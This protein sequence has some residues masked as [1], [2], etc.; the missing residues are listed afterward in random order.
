M[1]DAR[2]LCCTIS[3]SVLEARAYQQRIHNRN[4]RLMRQKPAMI[5]ADAC[6]HDCVNEDQHSKMHGCTDV[7]SNAHQCE[8][9]I[10]EQLKREIH[11]H[12][13]VSLACALSRAATLSYWVTQHDVNCQ[14]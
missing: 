8:Q 7:Q 3:Q 10:I 12:G 4:E 13:A 5:E 1:S 9:G 14:H 2:M 6:A 11:K